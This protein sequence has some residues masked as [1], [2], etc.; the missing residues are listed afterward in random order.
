MILL[1]LQYLT[2]IYTVCICLVYKGTLQ[3]ITSKIIN[4]ILMRSYRWF[5]VCNLVSYFNSFKFVYLYYIFH[6]CDKQ[7]NIL[8]IFVY[9]STFQLTV[10]MLGVQISMVCVSD[11]VKKKMKFVCLRVMMEKNQLLLKKKKKTHFQCSK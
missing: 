10:G 9:W 11:K 7:K 3:C 1:I 5:W 6:I 8:S 4:I 2:L